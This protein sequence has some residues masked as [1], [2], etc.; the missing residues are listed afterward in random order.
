MRVLN[1]DKSFN[2]GYR[3]GYLIGC[4]ARH[5]FLFPIAVLISIPIFPILAIIGIITFAMNL[6][7]HRVFQKQ[8]ND[9]NKF[10]YFGYSE[11]H[12]YDYFFGKS[13]TL[14]HISAAVGFDNWRETWEYYQKSDKS[15]QRGSP[16]EILSLN[17]WRIS[18]MRNHLPFFVIF[19]KRYKLKVFKVSEPYR[20]RG[21]DKGAEIKDIESEIL[22]VA[23]GNRSL[24]YSITNE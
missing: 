17:R 18:N 21:R 12:Q 11:S 10:I 9:T 22:K 23:L 5:P 1:Q 8:F 24:I 19:T 4:L 7:A 14:K 13:G 2:S 20:K 6:Y 3:Y 16:F 15:I